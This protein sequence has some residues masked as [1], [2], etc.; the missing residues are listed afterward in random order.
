MRLDKTKK[1]L[2]VIVGL[3]CSSLLLT[4]FKAPTNHEKTKINLNIISNANKSSTKCS[5]CHAN[6]KNDEVFKASSKISSILNKAILFS[7]EIKS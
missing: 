7:S 6:K 1:L 2:T 3:V 4:G 5:S